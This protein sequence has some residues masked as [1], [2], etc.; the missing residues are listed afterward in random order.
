MN[1]LITSAGR[2]VSLVKAFQK[3]LKIYWPEA[4]VFTADNNIQLSAACQLS[5][6]AFNLPLVEDKNYLKLLMDICLKNDIKLIIPTI[7]TE[8]L[9]LSQNKTDF[10][11]LGIT[12]LISSPSFIEIC[13]NK[14]NVNSFF[15]KNNIRVAKEFSK[16]AY[17]LPLFIKP[18]SG[19]RSVDT[20]IVKKQ[21]ELRDYFFENNDLLFLEYLD[22]EAYEEFTC[23]LYY[24]KNSELKCVVPRKRIEVR[25]GEVSKAVTKKNRLVNYI[26]A[27]LGYIEGAIGCLCA[28]FFM[29]KSEHTIYGIEINARFGGGFPLT[30]SSGANY[31]RWIIEEYVFD[32]T[33]NYY[34]AWET[35]LL[36]LRY[37]HEFLIHGFK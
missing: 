31:P 12:P 20:Y 23:D 24:D 25:D 10:I 11:N 8:L 18:I 33:L 34:D 4:Q 22:H 13:R 17:E 6:Q 26:K 14:R 3:E 16:D 37:D 27:H 2:R 19:S 5:D 30:Y 29:H 35:D 36:M 1:I 21:E 28:Q 15:E 32:K 9:L 7:D